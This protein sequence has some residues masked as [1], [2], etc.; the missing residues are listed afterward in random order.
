MTK[1]MSAIADAGFLRAAIHIGSVTS[2]F[3]R[4]TTAIRSLYPNTEQRIKILNFS[5][6]SL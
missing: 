4:G 1:R 3:S 5:L 6:S 2:S